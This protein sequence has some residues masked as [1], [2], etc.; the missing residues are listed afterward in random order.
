LVIVTSIVKRT[1]P[2]NAQVFRIG[3]DELAI[4][5]PR[6]D[7]DV[8][9]RFL[10]DVNAALNAVNDP[11]IG[12]PSLSWGY[13]VMRDMDEDY[14][15]VFRAADVIMYGEKKKM[16]TISLSGVMPPEKNG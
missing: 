7:T 11:E 3:G 9:E 10:T 4:L 1:I 12:T 13:A 16:K 14:N 5:I 15:A 6:A 8:A 2:E